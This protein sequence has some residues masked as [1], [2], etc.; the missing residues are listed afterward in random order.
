ML[1]CL[2]RDTGEVL[3]EHKSTYSWSSP[4]LVYNTDGTGSVIYCDYNKVGKNMFLLNALTGD[5]LDSF[6]LG[7][8]VEASPAVY[9]DTI[10][11]GTRACKI[12]GV[13]LK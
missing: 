9:E 2:D 12:W 7:G 10:V 13:K 8:G 1:A 3:W 6:N 4:V 5:V 11:I